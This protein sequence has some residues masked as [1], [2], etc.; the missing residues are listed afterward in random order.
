M[1]SWI[2]SMRNFA[3]AVSWALTGAM[4][5]PMAMAAAI[6]AEPESRR[7]ILWFIGSPSLVS[8]HSAA[9]R[10]VQFP[11]HFDCVA[12]ALQRSNHGKR[13][14]GVEAARG[15]RADRQ[16]DLG[17]A[18]GA[19]RLDR[20]ALSA[21]PRLAGLLRG[22]ARRPGGRPL[23]HRAGRDARARDASLLLRRHRRAR[24]ALRNGYRRGGADR[25]HA[26]HR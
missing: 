15:L 8:G 20:L 21:A 7:L 5:P 6:A 24:D 18:R 11:Y 1:L 19:R 22:A 10:L 12:R 16:H 17:R 2:A 25:L 23:A 26:A 3:S 13:S 4:K 14:A 9:P